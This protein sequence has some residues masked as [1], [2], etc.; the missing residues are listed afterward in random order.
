MPQKNGLRKTS[1]LLVAVGIILL[2]VAFVVGIPDNFPGILSMLVGGFA[3]ILGVI[4]YARKPG[5]RTP[6]QQFLY[7]A[8]RALCIAFALFISLFALDAFHEGQGFWGIILALLMHLI[9]T[10][11][12]LIVLAVSWRREWIGGV[13]F[14]LLGVLYVAWTW[15]K[16]IGHS[17]TFAIITGPLVLTGA[18]F[19]LN[20]RYRSEL[21]RSSS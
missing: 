3:V 8:P 5:T 4:F 13:L 10:F 6:A 20:W 15:N 9:P 16:P 12:I 1:Y 18:L 2:T 17:S 21:K 7:W 14:I 19:L 11:L